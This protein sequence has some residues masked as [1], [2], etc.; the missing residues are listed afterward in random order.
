MRFSALPTGQIE[1][2]E[3]LEQL[4]ALEHGIS[5][6]VWETRHPSLRLDTPE[7]VTHAVAALQ[8][9]ANSQPQAKVVL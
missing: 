5:I 9:S 2:T 6:R 7:D 8:V 1:E 4:R 3:K